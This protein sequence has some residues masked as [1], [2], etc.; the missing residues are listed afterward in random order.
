[1]GRFER[2]MLKSPKFASEESRSLSQVC[3]ALISLSYEHR[4]EAKIE[5]LSAIINL[6]VLVSVTYV[7]TYCV[8]SW[9]YRKK[10]KSHNAPS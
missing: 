6:L 3:S 8:I 10:E 4:G 1:M 2:V 5:I 9:K 7:I